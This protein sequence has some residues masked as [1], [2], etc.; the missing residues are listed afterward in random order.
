MK[1]EKL[2]MEDYGNRRPGLVEWLS[3]EVVEWLFEAEVEVEKTEA[4]NGKLET[5]FSIV[6]EW[7]SC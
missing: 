4:G 1:D 2:K 3:G 6:V 7:R 5:G